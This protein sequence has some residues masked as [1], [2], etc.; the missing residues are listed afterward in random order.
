MRSGNL[1]EVVCE[2]ESVAKIARDSTVRRN[3]A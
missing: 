3:S 2:G 1:D